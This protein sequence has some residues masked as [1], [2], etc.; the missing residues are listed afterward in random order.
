MEQE[1][2]QKPPE[3]VEVS[4]PQPVE[5]TVVESPPTQPSRKLAELFR[6]SFSVMSMT[7]SRVKERVPVVQT[8]TRVFV[9][10]SSMSIRYKI[11]G[12]LV[13]VLALAIAS[14]GFVTFSRQ[15][16]VL[17]SEMKKRAEVLVQQLANV[18]KEGL[19]TRDEL[20]IYQTIKDIQQNSGVVYAMVLDSKG[21][22]FAHNLLTEKGKTLDTPTDLI[23][24]QAET[25]LFQNW[26]F[27]NLPIMDASLPVMYKA[28]NL[29]LGT[30][31]IGLSE[32]ELRDEISRQKL[33]FFWI[34]MGFVAIGL[35]IA[36][37]L[38]RVLTQPIYTLAVAI[39]MVAGGD[40]SQQVK[41]FY[42][43]EIGRLTESFNQMILSLRE[44]LHM[45]KYLSNSALKSIRK[46]RDTAKLRLGGERKQVTALF[47]DVRG[48]TSMSEKLSPEEVVKIL[49]IYL[50][51]QAKVI[52]HRGGNVDKYVGDEVMAIFEGD[53]QEL[54]A[55]RAGLEIQKYCH[56]LNWSR[57]KLSEKQMQLGIGIHSG[58]VVMGNMGS[59]E[60]MNYTVIGDNINLAARLCS[61]AKAG[62]VVISKTVADILGKKA[63]LIKLEPVSVKGKEKP[64]EIY[65]VS[66]VDGVSR[67]YMRRGIESVVTYH[68][69]GLSDEINQ[70]TI[71]NLGAD[72]CMLEINSAVGVGSK[73]VVNT[74]SLGIE[75]VKNIKGIVKHAHKQD[76]KYIV[77][78]SFDRLP[79][80]SRIHIT[81]WVHRVE[82]EITQTESEPAL[83]N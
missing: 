67:R 46:S 19:L 41:V 2:L 14:L 49:N 75:G 24:A 26:I 16:K 12:A 10:V 70:S 71:R 58:E 13:M 33:A 64:I 68:L 66:D 31:R 59:E 50:N 52:T 37:G 40:L 34:S 8:Y 51:L 73:L 79:E 39:Q 61:A 25:L 63:K 81:Q 15:K 80:K 76:T 1:E 21:Q 7:L 55:V 6:N 11:A 20:S 48:F 54:S 30:A 5:T 22:V 17:E 60:Q 72:G 3:P 78:V 32:K 4:A 53:D 36:F 44:K 83:L 57:S 9:L 47:S 45:E 65:E 43:D 56:A 18:G 35:L 29:R 23:A 69:E 28:K 38:S 62:Q 27:N 77:G 42:R 74:E 82:S